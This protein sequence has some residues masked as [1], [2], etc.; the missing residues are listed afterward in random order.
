MAKKKS[1]FLKILFL[2]IFLLSS[3]GAIIAY[4]FYN[5]IYQPNVS[6]GDK[7]TEYFYVPTGSTIQDVINLLY[8]KNFILNRNSF[9]WVA[10]KKNYKDN[11]HPGRFLLRSGMNNEELI[12]LLRSGKQEP[13]RVTFNNIRLKTELIGTVAP[14]LE[15]D[16]SGISDL[17]DQQEYCNK[18]GF[19][20]ENIMCMFIPN[21]Y[22]FD[23]NTSAEQFI[24]RM[25]KEYQNFWTD[26]RQN[27]AKNI[28]LTQ[29]QVSILASIVQKE[30]NRNDEKPRVAGVYLNRIRKDMLL[31]AD[32]TLVFALKEFTLKRVLNVHKLVDSPYNTYMYKGLPPGPICLPEISSIDAVL[33]YEKHDYFYFC[34]REDFS[35]YHNFA[36][37]YA[38]HCLNASRF[39]K[40]LNKQ[41]IF[42]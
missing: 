12:D 15:A 8:E 4:K 42:K 21:S 18:F 38:Q 17:L 5:I 33:N 23:W 32:P 16:S 3:I 22:Q 36:K 10:D 19:N 37:N 29:N 31:Q 1:S 14:H 20:K 30:T 24:Q 25:S 13:V 7:K 27:K 41:K 28:G 9:E 35:G 34:A 2:F 11:V 40:E 39:Q 6:L 26:D